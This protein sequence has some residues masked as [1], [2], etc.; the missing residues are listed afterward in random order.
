[1]CDGAHLG[2]MGAQSTEQQFIK[3]FPWLNGLVSGSPS[4]FL[5]NELLFCK[6]HIEQFLAGN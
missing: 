6:R 5:D 2:G 1:M 3:M 4:L